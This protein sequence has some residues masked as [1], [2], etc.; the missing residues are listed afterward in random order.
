MRTYRFWR[1]VVII[2]SSVKLLYFV[3]AG[4]NRGICN[5]LCVREREREGRRESSV[6]S[7][8]YICV[9]AGLNRGICR[10]LCVRVR[11]R[12]REGERERERERGSLSFIVKSIFMEKNSENKREKCT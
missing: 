8:V 12:Q 2:V 9:I 5:V 6:Y 11:E 10:V 7:Q 3:I 4:L 1:I